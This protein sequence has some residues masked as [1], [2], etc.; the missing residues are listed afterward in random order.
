MAEA[1]RALKQSL[2][3]ARLAPL[4]VRARAVA[5]GL[6]MGAHRSPRR[7]P[8][9][10]FGGHRAYLP[11]D[12]L[13]WLDRRALM[14]HGR[15]LVREFET[16]T[17]RALRLIVDAT[18][19]M[20]YRSEHAPMTKLEYASLLAA[21]LAR[22]A[23]SGGDPVALDWLGGSSRR[24]LPAMGGREAFERIVACLEGAGP[25]G[26]LRDD[27]R[28][29]DRALTP[30]ATHARRGSVLVL[31]SDMLDLPDA[32]LDRFLALSVRG[33]I[34][35]AVQVLDPAE[36][37]FPF[38]GPLRLRATEGSHTVETDGDAVRSEY[39]Q[40]L[41]ALIEH[42]RQR[43]A[44]VGGRLVLSTTDDDPVEVVRNVLAAVAG[45]RP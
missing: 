33:R 8:G 35:V 26:E 13:R 18:A 37:R 9:V 41:E 25:A 11:G 14:R 38:R 42:W 45:E 31:L 28:S 20:G 17:D 12:D 44:S 4:S 19:S 27:T 7:G 1:K 34:L 30:V 23:Q 5:D 22:V 29:L 21:A 40:R 15:L 2:D 36:R 16:D 10:E 32:A 6:Y 24:P 39:L 43:L 3:W